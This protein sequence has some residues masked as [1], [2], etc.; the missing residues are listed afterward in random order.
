MS[1]FFSKLK[2]GLSRI[3]LGGIAFFMIAVML[4]LFI[5]S[6]LGTSDMSMDHPSLE[7]V[8]FENDN[9]PL[10]MVFLILFFSLGMGL[11]LVLRRLGWLE[12][13][14]SA[15]LSWILLAWVFVMGSLWVIQSMSAPTHD[16]QIVTHA[17]V[18]IANGDI[19]VL[20]KAYFTRFPFQLGYVFW[21]ELWA[22]AFGLNEGTYIFMEFV[23]VL[24]LAFGEMALVRLTE[25][26][27]NKR[28]VTFATALTLAL[29]IQPMIFC[30]FLYGT[31][32]GFCFAAW[33][34]LL[35][36]RY[37]QTD[38][39]Q[40]IIGAGLAL[41]ISVALKLNN[42]ILLVAMVII[43]L[44]HVLK[45]KSLR[46]LISVAI[47][48]VMV[49]T[50]K[51]VGL[52]HYEASTGKD[53]GDGIPMTS[54]MAMGLNDAVSAPGWYSYEY[55]I[56]NFNSVDGDTDAANKKSIEEIKERADYFL[57]NPNEAKSFFSK[58]ILSQW[59]EPT[60]QSLWNNQ[61]R[62]QYMDKFGFAEWA[63][64]EGEYTVKAWMDLGVQFIFFGM[65][66]AVV[67]LFISQCK[68][69]SERREDES[70]LW[71]IP[72]CI[73]GGFIYHAL[74]EGKS[75]YV[76]TYVTYMIPFAIWGCS[77]LCAALNSYLFANNE[78][79][80]D[81]KKLFRKNKG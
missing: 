31:M 70:A 66:A 5:G 27:F 28:E 6:M 62:G 9:L 78:K 20:D 14:T 23:N 17:G 42:L 81:N 52:W 49:L 19:S 38:K 15:R 8:L 65:L 68:N 41:A 64:G 79:K 67:F 63:C 48:L 2:C 32:P 59:N 24:C 13:L 61:V 72:L 45:K 71:L 18:A 4:F 43:L 36:V 60:Y 33:S 54:W 55:T 50:L 35:F 44:I 22:R 56:G 73:L 47:L 77:R 53:F 16:S 3:C 76:I 30:T 58:K 21:T 57:K 69:K 46:R 7:M 40:Y 26:L 80:K 12:R 74:F 51:N 25:R 34:V 10:N 1:D 39:W 37:L 11:I 75:Q 29:F